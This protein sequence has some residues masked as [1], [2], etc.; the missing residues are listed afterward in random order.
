MV[1]KKSLLGLFFGACSVITGFLILT[2]CTNDT[3][4][5]LLGESVALEPVAFVGDEYFVTSNVRNITNQEAFDLMLEMPGAVFTLLTLVDEVMLRGVVDFE[6]DEIDGFLEELEANVEDVDAWLTEHGFANMDEVIRVFEVEQMRRSAVA[7]LIVV[8][9]EDVDEELE[10]FLEQGGEYYEGIRD[11]VYAFLLSQ[12]EGEVSEVEMARLRFEAGFEIFNTTLEE[13]YE[14]YLEM[15]QIEIG[16]NVANAQNTADVVAAVNGVEITVGQLFQAFARER[17]LA[18]VFETLDPLI[19]ADNFEV[20]QADVEEAIAEAREG[21]GDDFDSLAASADIE[22]EAQLLEYFEQGLLNQAFHDQFIPDEPRLRELYEE[23]KME[24]EDTVS[25]SHILVESH[26][27]AADLI[28]Q[29]Q[30]ADDFSLLFAELAREY[31]SCGS[32]ASGGD[33]GSWERGNMVEP[34]DDAIFALEV[35]EFTDEPVQTQFGYHVIYKTGDGGFE[36]FREQLELQELNSLQH[37]GVI[38][39]ARMDLRS[40]AAIVFSDSIIQARFEALISE[41]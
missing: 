3:G 16:T 10:S 23:M 31:S 19:L 39:R 25:G 18:I 30:D 5:N 2:G 38:D 12:A 29:L 26:E 36:D 9:E 13:E 35:G 14:L 41:A 6:T 27:E 20:S 11:D 28:A 40:E 15:A 17:G 34:F 37:E 33:L 1:K 8:T 32:A 7:G 4:S 22:T 24:M 21:L